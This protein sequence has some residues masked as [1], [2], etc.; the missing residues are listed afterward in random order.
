[1]QILDLQDKSKWVNATRALWHKYY[2]FIG[3]G[4]PK[5]GKATLNKVLKITNAAIK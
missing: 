5:Q 3:Y 1:M 4:D 2:K